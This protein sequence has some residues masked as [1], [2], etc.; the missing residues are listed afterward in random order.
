MITPYEISANSSK[1]T[2]NLSKFTRNSSK[3][4]EKMMESGD[5]LTATSTIQ[6]CLHFGQGKLLPQRELGISN[7]AQG[8]RS[9]LDGLG[10]A[11][12]MEDGHISG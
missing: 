4:I 10:D 3:I 2:R 6:H 8:A 12:Q 11:M 5:S 7:Q 9:V 1:I